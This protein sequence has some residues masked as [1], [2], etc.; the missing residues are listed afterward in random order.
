[1]KIL[2][3]GGGTGGHF[4]P[5]IAIA[6]ELNHIADEEKIANFKLYYM[7]DVPYN[8][9]ELDEQFI[10]FIPITAG[11][12]RVY[13]S[14]QNFVDMG[15]TAVGTVGAVFK[16]FSL[17]PDVIISKGGYAAFPVLVA[18]KILRI[19]VIIH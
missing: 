1:M 11:K 19:P 2:L 16:L 17:Y 10:T 5:L 14:L 7:A 3:I 9:K 18:A 13:F 15:K 4:Y 12:L 6:E 8:Q